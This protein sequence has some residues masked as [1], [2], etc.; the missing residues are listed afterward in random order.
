MKLV[1]LT[2]IG[3]YLGLVALV[4][5]FQRDLMYVPERKMPTPQV[6][7]VAEMTAYLLST[8][9]GLDLTSWYAPPRTHG[10][11]VIVL[12]HGNAGT[13]AGRAFKARIF[14]DAG[15]GVMLVGYRGYGN[16]PGSPN[17]NG[18]YIDSRAALEFLSQQ[19]I[20]RDRLILYGESL[21]CAVAIQTALEIQRDA[22]ATQSPVIR[23]LVLEAP[24]TSMGD[25]AA[26]H[27]PW[28]PARLLVKDDFKSI[29]KI[30]RLTMPLFVVHGGRDLTVPQS[31]GRALFDLA[32]EPKQALWIDDAGHNDLYDE[33]LTPVL[34]EWM[35]AR[36]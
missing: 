8:S 33:G 12:Y 6:A 17:E 34:L 30:A 20:A 28:L 36:G 3:C 13:L 29:E 19:G 9:D 25:A 21:G 31:H 4:Y 24:F 22:E 11:P 32:N 16:N 7:G 35:A 15:Y 14:L 26:V 1:I 2:A 27:Y 23:G 5:V 18:L 10:M